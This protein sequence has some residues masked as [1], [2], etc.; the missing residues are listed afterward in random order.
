[1]T[2]PQNSCNLSTDLRRTFRR[3]MYYRIRRT[4]VLSVLFACTISTI[5]RCTS[6]RY[7]P[8]EFGYINPLEP[9]KFLPGKE[10]G[11]PARSPYDEQIHHGFKLPGGPPIVAPPNLVYNGSE[12][13][14]A[15]MP[16][17]HFGNSV[18]IGYS[19][20]SHDFPDKV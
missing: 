6:P 2:A 16:S 15:A 4:L 3:S 9:I 13:T 7:M 17:I 20:V 10:I 5:Y 1:M 18:L 14:M 12:L 8:A 19:Y 11:N